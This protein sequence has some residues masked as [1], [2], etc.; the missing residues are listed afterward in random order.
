MHRQGEYAQAWKQISSAIST[1]YY[2]RESRHDE[3]VRLLAKYKPKAEGAKDDVEFSGAVNGMIEEFKDS[4]FGLFTKSDQGY[5]VMDGLV[6]QGNAEE[7]PMFGAYFGAKLAD[8]YT[9]KMVLNKTEAEASDIRKGDVIMKINNQ[10]FTPVDSMKDKVGETVDLTVR[11]GTNEMHKKVKISKDSAMD[12]F[13]TASRD[14][15]RVIDY[16]GKKI[17]YF[18]LWTQGN[19]SFKNALAGAVSGEL[20]DTDA[21]ILDIRD[22]FGG[23]PE[24]YMDPFYRPDVSLEWKTSPKTGFTQ[25]FGYGKPMVLLINGGSRSAKEVLS[26]IVKKSKRATLIGSTTAGNVLGTS[27]MAVAGRYYLEIP[28]VDVVTDGV[29][30]EGKGVA[31]D[32]AIPA[33]FDEAGKDMYL[34]AALKRLVGMST[35]A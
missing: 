16:K 28:M 20:K 2:A 9:V 4:H 19:E 7:M 29:R 15:A 18:H 6:R 34:E 8:G 3:M 27:P 13:L 30:L 22:G 1:R 14:S 5:Y 24:G 11:R 21:F 25:K 31:P 12:M 17:G 33:E 32:I 26:Y 35:K 10:P 23:R